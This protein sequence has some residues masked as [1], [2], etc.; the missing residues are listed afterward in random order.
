[1]KRRFVSAPDG[2]GI[3]C[4]VAW[5]APEITRQHHSSKNACARFDDHISL[6]PLEKPGWFNGKNKWEWDIMQ[7]VNIP[8]NKS[9]ARRSFLKTAL[10]GAAVGLAG[11]MILYKKFGCAS[12]SR[13]N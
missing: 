2:D 5:T 9:L 3:R 4:R 11:P 13:F 12:E 10:A 6:S 7:R 8:D 1:M